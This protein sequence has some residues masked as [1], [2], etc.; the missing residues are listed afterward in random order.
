MS[1]SSCP[2]PFR[3]CPLF[4]TSLSPTLIVAARVRATFGV[5]SSPF[6]LPYLLPQDSGEGTRKVRTEQGSVSLCVIGT[7]GP[8][9]MS[10]LK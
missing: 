7:H 5:V 8:G 6:V 9:A 3:A 10:S 2:L 4:G 1:S